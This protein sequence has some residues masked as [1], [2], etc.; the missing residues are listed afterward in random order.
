MG[1]ARSI[2]QYRSGLAKARPTAELGENSSTR[3]IFEAIEKPASN[4]HV[5]RAAATC[6]FGYALSESGLLADAVMYR[7]QEELMKLSAVLTRQ[8]LAAFGVAIE[9]EVDM[10]QRIA[11]GPDGERNL[12]DFLH[13]FEMPLLGYL[14][15][16]PFAW[17]VYQLINLPSLSRYIP[18]RIQKAQ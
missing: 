10:M 2:K 9:Q 17:S 13:I 3:L 5:R 12:T 7:V 4:G 14:G 16:V 6:F 15:Y 11:A 18:S 8:G 1:T